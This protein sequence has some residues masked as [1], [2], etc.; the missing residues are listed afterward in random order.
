MYMYTCTVLAIAGFVWRREEDPD[1]PARGV[2][3]INIYIY[4]CIP[5]SPSIN[6]KN[7]CTYPCRPLDSRRFSAA[8]RRSATPS[9]RRAI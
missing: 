7:I 6:F 8:R 2:L 9:W 1:H 3:Y 5:V 4:I